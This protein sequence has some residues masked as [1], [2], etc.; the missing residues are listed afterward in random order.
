MA[1][2]SAGFEAT[3]SFLDRGDNLTHMRFGVDGADI[4][5]AEVIIA[6]N[7]AD[8]V[9]VTKAYVVGYSIAEKFTNDAARTKSANGEIEEK[10]VIT[11]NLETAPKKAILTIPAPVDTIFAGADGDLWNTVDGA[12]SLLVAFLGDFASGGFQL[13]DGE[14]VPS[15]GFFV[16]GRRTHRSSSK[17]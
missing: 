8:I 11:V 7:I 12:D 6:A 2:N 9:A 17:G 15:T 14:H 10:A 16:K 4:A 1:F 3:V 5:A 13:S